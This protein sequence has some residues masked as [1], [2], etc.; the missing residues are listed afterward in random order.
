M[1]EIEKVKKR[2]EGRVIQKA[3]Y[4]EEMALLARERARAEF[5]DWEKKEEEGESCTTRARGGGR[6]FLNG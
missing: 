3:Q 2:R 4:E 6:R 5:Q 1:A